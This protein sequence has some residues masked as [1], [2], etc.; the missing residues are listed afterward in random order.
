M[1]K[2]WDSMIN[3]LKN[4]KGEIK[5]ITWPTKQEL[6]A[7]TIVVIITLII[8]TVFLYVSNFVLVGLFNKINTFVK[9]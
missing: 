2:L 6:R 3:Y 9:G 4:V 8:V 7:A 5:R 1:K